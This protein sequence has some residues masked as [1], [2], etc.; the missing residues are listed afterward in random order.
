MALAAFASVFMGNSLEGALLLAMFNLAHI[1]NFP[2]VNTHLI[3]CVFIFSCS[4]FFFFPCFIHLRL[5][6]KNNI[7]LFSGRIF[8]MPGNGWC[9]GTKRQPSWFCASAGSWQRRTTI[10]KTKLQ[11][12]SCMWPRSGFQYTCQG[13]WGML[14]HLNLS[15]IS[16]LNNFCDV[17]GFP[18]CYYNTSTSQF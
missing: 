2:L 10:H 9:E 8:H 14:L 17:F 15:C 12:G 11:K 4:C 13:W 18:P 3:N 6:L 5:L 7:F 1:G 16:V